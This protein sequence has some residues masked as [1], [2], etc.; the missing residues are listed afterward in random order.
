MP[1]DD[2]P[3]LSYSERDRLLRDR[4]SGHA[5]PPRGRRAQEESVKA[6]KAALAQADALFTDEK[7]G[8]KGKALASAVRE[9][10]GSDELPAA[11][12]AYFDEVGVPRDRELLSIFLDSG[13]RDLRVA[14]LDALLAQKEAGSLDLGGGLKSQLRM[15]AD[16]FDDAIASRAEEI[17]E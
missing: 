17:L 3:K 15:L 10:H 14:A 6:T 13:V 16:E 7:G 8:Q 4:K 11:C 2:R 1:D 5:G 9:A 12:Q